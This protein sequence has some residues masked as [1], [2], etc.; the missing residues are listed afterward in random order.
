[1]NFLRSE[2][3]AAAL[4]LV[5]ATA[6]L[7]IANLPFGPGFIEVKDAHLE[8]P[9]LRLDLSAAHWISDGLLAVFFFIVAV[10]L[11]RELFIGELNSLSKA[12]APAI[13]AV[14]GVIVP[15]AIFL[16]FTSGTPTV[17]GWPIPTATDIAFALGVLAVLGGTC[18]RACEIFLLALAVLDDLIAILIIAF[19]FTSD[20][21]PRRARLRHHRDRAVRGGQPDPEASVELDPVPPAAMAD[22][23]ATRGARRVGL[24]FRLPLG[25]ACH[26]RGRR[27]RARHGS[28]SW[29]PGGAR[30]GA[31]VERRHPAVVRLHRSDGSRAAGVARAARP[32]VLGHPRGR[33]RSARSSASRSSAC[34]AGS[35][36]DRRPAHRSRSATSSSSV[37]SAASDS[38]S[39]SS[40]T[41][42][43]AGLPGVADEGTLAVL[44]GSGVAIIISAI[45]V[46]A[47]SRRYRRLGEHAGAGGPFAH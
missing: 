36:R 1:M 37:L 47:Q 16:A 15:A 11:K 22:H 45:A 46:T 29:R 35:L 10:E 44:L 2:R 25:R 13:A 4:L 31:M 40:S 26:H 38:R 43:V 41:T 20:A 14:G 28:P 21:E 42:R 27:P 19:F 34:S 3:W 24:V 39:R 12:L 7:V 9:F 18:R 33:F 17:D 5:A 23:A 8:F 30:A 6:G 32:G